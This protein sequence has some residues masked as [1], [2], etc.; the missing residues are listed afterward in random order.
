MATTDTATTTAATAAPTAAPTGNLTDGMHM[1]VEALLTNGLDKMYGVIG[2]PVTDVARIGQ[3]EGIRYIGLRHE[4]DAGNAAAAAGFITGKPGVFITVSA[5]GF[6]NGITALKEATENGWPVI[7]ISGS[8]DRA[9]AGFITGKPGVFITVSAPGFLN[10]ITAL[11][12]ATEN[13]WPVIQISGS[14]DRQL[15][16]MGEGDY[17]GLDQYNF[18]KPFCK[19]AYRIDKP[20]DIALGVARAIRAAVSGRPGGVYLDVPGELLGATMDIDAAKATMYQVNDPAPAMVPSQE[21]ID[22]ALELL[23]GAKNPLIYL[24]KGAAYAQAD[25]DIQDFVHQTGIPYLAMS[26]AKGLIPDTDPQNA[27]S[28]RGL[29]MRTADVVLLI[30]ARL[31]WMLNFG[32]GKHWNENVKFIQ[33]EIDPTEI[34]NSRQIDAPI[35]GDIKSAMGMLLEGLKTTPV[36]VDPAWPQLLQAD[37]EK[38]N[39]KFA[40]KTAVVTS[41]MNHYNALGAIKKVIDQHPEVYI[42]NDGANALDICRDVID[43]ALPRHRL[44]CGTW[45]VMGVATPYA[46]AAAVETG[47]PVVAISVDICRDVIDMALPRHRLDCGTWGVMGVATPYAIA[48]AVETGDPVVAISGDCAFGFAGMEIETIAR[49]GLPVTQIVLNNGGIYRGD[50]ENLGNDGDPSPLTLTASGRYEKIMEAFGG[51]SYYATTPEELEQYLTEAI[52][53]KKPAMINVQLSIHSGKESG[54]ISYLNPQP[55]RGPLATSEMED[56]TKGQ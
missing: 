12:E 43:M 45:G 20:E 1:L 51:A 32:K 23:A 54:H 3:G 37:I 42:T 18:A 34:D 26:M 8:S 48:A 11:K 40:A 39:A 29:A 14:S 55:V 50:F 10:G 4:S 19:A 5:P 33:I 6:L 38:N 2:I 13:G 30:G 53:S 15:I 21:S 27:G 44:D 7:Q 17:E 47:D 24:G 41:P 16:D 22:K 56:L 46:I 25:K 36:K 49:Y 9:A 35:V 31:N 52:A 28:A